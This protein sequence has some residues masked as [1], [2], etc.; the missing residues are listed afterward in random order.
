MA[1]PIDDNQNHAIEEAMEQFVDSQLWEQEP[2]VD[3][4]VKQYPEFEHQIRKRIRKIQKIHAL[5][6]SLVQADESDF[7]DAAAGQELVGQKVGNFEIAEIIGR[8]GMG[9]VY[10]ARDTRLDRLVAI[11]SIPARQK[12]SSTARMRFKREAKLLASLNHS[13]IAVIYDI[14]ETDDGDDFLVLE[15][16]PGQTLA[17]LTAQKPLKLKQ[18]L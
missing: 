13:N 2:N 8:G 4:F 6:D 1:K 10:L 7:E 18:A 17:E 3:E 5:F 15:Y 12:E 9:V 14:I 11:K 16:V